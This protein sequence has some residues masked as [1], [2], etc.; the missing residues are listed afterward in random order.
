MGA[1]F[2]AWLGGHGVGRV[3]GKELW[4]R[5]R[6]RSGLRGQRDLELWAGGQWSLTEGLPSMDVNDEAGDL[7]ST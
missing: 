4:G 5:G 3:K 1:G 7:V 2:L 6:E